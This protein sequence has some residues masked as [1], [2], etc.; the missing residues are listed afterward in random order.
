MNLHELL[1]KAHAL[2]SKAEA[3]KRSLTAAEKIEFD[4]LEEQIR[5]QKVIDN[6]KRLLAANGG[7]P[8][9]EPGEFRDVNTGEKI[10][11]FNRGESMAVHYRQVAHQAGQTESAISF[12]QTLK[13]LALGPK[14]GAEKRA[15][16]EGTMSAG[17]YTVPTVTSSELIDL[18]RAKSS[19]LNAGCRTV[20]LTSNKVVMARVTADP[21]VNWRAEN[22][23]I[24]SNDMTFD[25]VTFV[26][27]ALSTIVLCSVELLQ[28][29]VNIDQA[30]RQSIAGAMAGE[31]DRVS[32]IG[33][34]STNQPKGIS[35]ITGVGSVSMG[36]NG[37]A[38]ASWDPL[39]EPAPLASG[40]HCQHPTG[41]LFTSADQRNARQREPCIPD[42]YRRLHAL[43]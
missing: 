36:T 35:N 3:E 14:S 13:A 6:E 39:S 30:L 24:N 20:D 2:L 12:G 18:M 41:V 33:T 40:T 5:T 26:P 15:L 32:L 16:S 10:N 8:V 43:R 7:V 37:L 9:V 29:S 38:P 17:G 31:I 1:Q 28:D 11:V 22:A 23:V 34:G 25:S 21:A 42:H 27:V 19:V 4:L